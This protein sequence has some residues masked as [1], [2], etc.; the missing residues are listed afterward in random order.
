GHASA[1]RA[2]RQL[3]KLVDRIESPWPR[4]GTAVKSRDA[5]DN[6]PPGQA[7]GF[8][9]EHRKSEPCVIVE[10]EESSVATRIISGR[11][12][13]ASPAHCSSPSATRNS[14]RIR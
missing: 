9:V 5:N 1:D 2:G 14:I 11:C 6:K 13:G 8:H 4:Q 12:C 10:P 3:F 7:G